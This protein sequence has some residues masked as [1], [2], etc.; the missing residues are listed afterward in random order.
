V[1]GAGAI[2]RIAAAGAGRMGRGIAQVFA[3]A[4]YRVDLV[5]LRPRAPEAARALGSAALEEIGANLAFLRER[6]VL[7]EVQRRA[8]LARIRFVAS[9][10]AP[11]ALAAADCVFEGVTETIEAKREALAQIGRHVSPEAL[12]AS[13]TSTILSDTLAAFVPGPGRFLNTHFLNPA[14]LIPLVEVMPASACSEASFYRMTAL[15]ESAGKV[16]VR[17]GQRPGYIVPRI[18]AAAMNEAARIVE[19]GAASAADVDRAVRAGFGPR[20]ATMG[21][22]EFIDFGGLDILYYAS[23]YLMRALAAER[24]RPPA[25]IEAKMRAGERGLREGVGLYDHRGRDVAAYTRELLARQVDMF[26]YMKLLPAPG[27]ERGA[28]A[29]ARSEVP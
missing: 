22:A 15:L 26:R 14:F 4:G 21:L 17:C 11:Q 16:C 24:F 6:G 29:Q 23:S 25:I 20:Y 19:E 18:Q 1:S 27:P 2:R 8:I 12:L 28:E 9:D 10:T 3:Y 7:D 5:D 13:T